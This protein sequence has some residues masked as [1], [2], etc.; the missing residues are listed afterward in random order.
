MRDPK[1]PYSAEEL[2][3]LYDWIKLG[4]IRVRDPLLEVLKRVFRRTCGSS[5]LRQKYNREDLL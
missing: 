4:R 1:V 3:E 5:A 2:E